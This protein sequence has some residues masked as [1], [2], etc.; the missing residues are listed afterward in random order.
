[1]S[2]MLLDAGA[3]VSCLSFFTACYLW[4]GGGGPLV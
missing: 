2:R 4:M 1:M 3:L